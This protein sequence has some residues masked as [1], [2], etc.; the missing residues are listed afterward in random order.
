MPSRENSPRS[1]EVEQAGRRRGG[2]PGER[3]PSGGSRSSREGRRPAEK[4]TRPSPPSAR[5]PRRRERRQPRPLPDRQRHGADDRPNLSGRLDSYP[6]RRAARWPDSQRLRLLRQPDRRRSVSWS[7][8]PARRRASGRTDPRR[9]STTRSEWA[10]ASSTHVA[11]RHRRRRP[12]P[13]REPLQGIEPPHD[14][15][16]PEALGTERRRERPDQPEQPLVHERQPVL[17][18]ARWRPQRQRLHRD[19]RA[20]HGHPGGPGRR[21]GHPGHRRRADGLRRRRAGPGRRTRKRPGGRQAGPDIPGRPVRLGRTS[22]SGFDCSGL[23]QYVY[24]KQ[25]VKLPRVA[26]DQA[27]RHPDRPRATAARR[28][29]LLRG[30][31]RLHPPRGHV[32]R[33]G[34]FIHAPRT[35]DVEDQLLYEPYY[36][37]QYARPAATA[38]GIV[39]QF[40]PGSPFLPV[41][42]SP[43]RRDTP[44]QRGPPPIR[45]S[46]RTCPDDENPR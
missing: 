23:V 26:E 29:R 16:D 18:R 33:G 43:R 6:R 32:R 15:P 35:G 39:S 8:S 46:A 22:P 38:P 42:G 17:H 34:Y 44:S 31:H 41:T 19:R 21:T 7:R 13:R 1:R 30:P 4:S 12:Q 10:P 37:T 27:G 3:P 11:G 2:S 36:A 5:R 9:R 40:L 28:R 45:G 20:G 25:G 14:R 24:A